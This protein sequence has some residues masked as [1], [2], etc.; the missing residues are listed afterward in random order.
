MKK[1]IDSLSTGILV[2]SSLI[3]GHYIFVTVGEYKNLESIQFSNA[4]FFNL[5]GLTYLIITYLYVHSAIYRKY[6]KRNF[7][8]KED[9][10]YIPVCKL[11]NGLIVIKDADTNEDH[12]IEEAD[13]KNYTMKELPSDVS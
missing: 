13:I 10:K 1:Y 7:L 8:L 9:K 3:L 6:V 5:V 11:Q 4:I 12:F 2:L